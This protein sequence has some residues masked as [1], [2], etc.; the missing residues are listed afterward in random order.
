M[1]LIQVS[2]SHQNIKLEEF[3]KLCIDLTWGLE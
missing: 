1:K 3:D 2:H